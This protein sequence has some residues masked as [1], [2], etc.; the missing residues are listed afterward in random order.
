[1][2]KVIINADDFGYSNSTNEAIMLG[3]K[4]GII[5]SA[6]LIVN[7]DGF[8]H[9]INQIFPQTKTLDLGFHF[10]ITEGMCLSNSPLLCDK[11]GHF[12]NGFISALIKSTDKKFINAVEV[13]FRLQIEKILKSINISHIDS[14]RH[15][16]AIP[17]IFNLIV[18]LAKEYNIKFIRTQKEVPYIVPSK[19]LDMKFYA[20]ILKSIVLNSLSNI[21]K[22]PYTNDKFIGILYT[23][24]MDENSILQGLKTIKTQTE[25]TEIIIHPTINPSNVNNYKE[26]MA[27]KSPKLKQEILDLGFKLTNYSEFN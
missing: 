26:F 9:A 17:P 10:N 14:H 22:Y 2:K 21:N 11:N 19:T 15:I 12:N 13:E 6:S 25:I 16:H 4:E 23:G 1:M 7:M 3:H 20:N 18:K 5:T 24:Y 8:D 27:I